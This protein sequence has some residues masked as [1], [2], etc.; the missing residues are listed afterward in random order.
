[1]GQRRGLDKVEKQLQ[2]LI[3]FCKAVTFFP[4]LRINEWKRLNIIIN[5]YKNENKNE[6]I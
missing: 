2:C 1:M 4:K 6:W 5:E 3:V